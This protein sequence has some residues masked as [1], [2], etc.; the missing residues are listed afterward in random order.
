MFSIRFFGS[1]HK[2]N[3]EPTVAKKQP[4]IKINGMTMRDTVFLIRLVRVSL[5]FLQTELL[6]SWWCVMMQHWYCFGQ[7]Q[8]PKETRKRYKIL[9]HAAI[10]H[11]ADGTT[12]YA[13]QK[14]C[15][16]GKTRRQSY[17]EMYFAF[18]FSSVNF[19]V[20]STVLRSTLKQFFPRAFQN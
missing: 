18:I 1:I 17:D 19:E 3:C 6:N 4:T 9:L 15:E 16:T 20:V 12:R 11:S 7:T 2:S 8:H 14:G 5:V 10:G 13:H